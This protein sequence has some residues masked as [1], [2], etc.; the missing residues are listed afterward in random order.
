MALIIIEAYGIID[1]V[2]TC[3]EMLRHPLRHREYVLHS[4]HL[5]HAPV[6]PF[7]LHRRT[8][9][10]PVEVTLRLLVGVDAPD[11]GQ[12]RPLLQLVEN[13]CRPSGRFAKQNR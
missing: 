2:H 10:D 3:R 6:E 12:C 1:V 13:I 5:A 4:V 9:P 7:L 8:L 11:E